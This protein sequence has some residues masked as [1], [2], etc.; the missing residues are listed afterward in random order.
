[1]TEQ[2]SS[3]QSD[4][5]LAAICEA[6]RHPVVLSAQQEQAF[7]QF[8]KRA[9]IRRYNTIRLVRRGKLKYRRVGVAGGDL[10][11]H[12]VEWDLR[13]AHKR[14]IDQLALLTRRQPPASAL[15]VAARQHK[16]SG[17][18]APVLEAWTLYAG[19][20]RLRTALVSRK[21]GEKPHYIRRVIR[22]SV[23]DRND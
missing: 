15:G 20:G 5:A 4:A 9:F 21:T 1:M 22:E 11:V 17:R 19:R 2:S 7:H 14:F 16:A 18:Q 8:R 12:P 13:K 6:L 3:D 23:R 10:P